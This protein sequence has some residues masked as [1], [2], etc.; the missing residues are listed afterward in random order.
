MSNPIPAPDLAAAQLAAMRLRDPSVAAAF[1]A[2]STAHDMRMWDK[3]V[4]VGDAWVAA[5]DQLPATAAVWYAQSLQGVGR[6]EEAMRWAHVA[7]QGMPQD[8]TIP[9]IAAWSTYA[10]SLARVGQVAKAKEAVAS[11]VSIRADHDETIEKQGHMVAVLALSARRSLPVAGRMVSPE[12]LWPLAWEMMEARLTQEEKAL[13]PG[14]RW[15]DG[16]TKEPVAVLHEQGMGDAILTA[17]WLPWLAEHTGHPVRYFGPQILSE[18]MAAMPGVELGDF[19][20]A[21][22]ATD[23]GAAIRCMSLPFHACGPI[24]NCGALARSFQPQ[25][26]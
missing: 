24:S 1:E 17:R 6:F 5:R 4:A 9:R 10:Q 25:H 8:E 21:Q 16:R 23:N 14:F 15:W 18:W 7:V 26:R 13:P 12:R 22:Q 2:M 11:A 3:V 20:A 19:D